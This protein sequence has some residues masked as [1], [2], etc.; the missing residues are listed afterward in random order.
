MQLAEREAIKQENAAEDLAA[1]KSQLAS[2]K[3]NLQVTQYVFVIRTSARV[4]SSKNPTEK[5]KCV[6][7]EGILTNRWAA[8]AFSGWYSSRCT[9]VYADATFAMMCAPLPP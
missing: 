5:K 3:A 7:L 9:A 2:F 6:L 8:C 4:E 1:M